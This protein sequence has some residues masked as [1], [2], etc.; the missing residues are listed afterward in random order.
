MERLLYEKL[1]NERNPKYNIITDIVERDGK[2]VVIKRPYNEEAKA[3]IHRVYDSYRG[4][5]EVLQGSD[6]CVNES[7]L[8][9]DAIESEFL[10]GGHIIADDADAF[11][12]AVKDAYMK[13]AKEFVSSPGF[14]E[15]FGQVDL[16]RGVLASKYLD[17]DLIFDNVIKT[18]KG[19]QIIDYEWTFDFLVPIN[20]VFYRASKFSDLPEHLVEISDAEKAVY[21]QMEDHFQS[22]YIF[23]DV[24]NLHELREHAN[25]R[26]KTSA[27]F[28]IASRDYQIKQLQE[29]IAAKDVHIRNIEASL[30][31]IKT[32]YDNTVNTRGYQTLESIRAFKSF[33]SGKDTPARQAKRAAKEEKKRAKQAAKEAKKLAAKG[34]PEPSIAIHLH[35][36]YVD[37]LPEFVSYFSNMPY[38]FDLY[39]SCQE[40]ADVALIK[41]GLK[42]LKKAKTIDIRPLPN[43]GRDLAP[44]YVKFANEILNHDYFLHIHSKKSL[45]SGQE[46]GGWRQF[47]LELL[48]GSEDKIKGI[49]DLFKNK[50][51]GIIYPDIQE[52]V[53]TIAYSWLANE[54]LGR[55]LFKEYDLG[56][57]PSVFNYPAGSFFWARCDALRPLLEHGYTYEDF[58]REQGQTDGTLAHALERILPFISR[59][60]GY[61]DYILYLNESDTVKNKSLRPFFNIFKMDKELLTMKLGAYDV[62]SFDIFDTLV[63]RGIFEPDDVFVLMEQIILNKY[64]KKVQFL[65]L[66]KAAE[67]EAAKK[68]GP[69]T[70]LDKIYVEVAKDKT[71]G[72]IAQDIKKLEVDLETRLCMPRKDMVEVFNTLKAMGRHVILVSDM[73]LNRAQMVG[74]LHKCGIGGYD[75]LIISCEVGARK[76]DGSMWDMLLSGINP[77]SF[78]HVGDNFRSDSQFLMDRGVNSHVVL[79]P[80]AML[81]LSDF[82]YLK[83]FA[84][85][86][87]ANSLM[88]GQAL[89]GGLFN[90]PFAYSDNGTLQFKDN[91]DFGYT[92]MG[93]LMA[94]FIQWIVENNKKTGEA[95][96]LLAREGYLLEQMLKDYCKNRG[97]DMPIAHYFL[98]SRRA[99]AVPAL[100]NDEDIRELL[101]QKYQGSFSNLLDERFGISIHEGDEDVQIDYETSQ[102]TLMAMIAPYKDEILKKAAVEKNSYLNYANQFI[103]TSSDLAVIDVGFSGTIQY[104]LMKLTGRDIAGHYMALHS[105]KPERIGG[106]ADAI[107]EI[108]DANKIGESKLLRYQLFLESAL[109][110]PTGQLINFTMEGGKP[111]PHYKDD[112]YVSPDVKRLQQGIMDFVKQFAD[113]TKDTMDGLLADT[114]LVEDLFYDIIANGTLTEEIADSLTVEDGYSRGG[115][116]KF[117]V[118]TGTWDVASP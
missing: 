115:V 96:L 19:W 116:Q 66:R 4:L 51:A 81:E 32:I 108:K 27:D 10:E 24:K 84:K 23:K 38:S 12:K 99:V 41:S 118:K 26:S 50:N 48:L 1:S 2:R 106:R 57:M 49:I 40:D 11:I 20:Y 60:Q 78:I 105:N 52:E 101:R 21:Q 82:A 70:T 31:Q 34:E 36:F 6:F 69:M 53:P 109:K 43:R 25:S 39:I 80:K 8:V 7:N 114:T 77:G 112:D 117:D 30:E 88:L 28:A 18:D 61:D 104:F 87:V 64:G 55:Q 93:P 72:N 29:L 103:A 90:S 62:V 14:E 33:L 76:D 91:Y 92:T 113:S 17:V 98:T 45:Y 107:Y 35:L 63:T 111:Q 9:G 68:Y 86:S 79:S 89:N 74:I 71:L 95:L 16:P 22:H 85:K 13:N 3:H 37:L 5:H 97:V 15:V 94:R 58:P 73:Y 102:D 110:A 59:K 83:D 100:E 65:K 46:K 67:A 42:E 56:D 44:L 75:E 54:G 47:S